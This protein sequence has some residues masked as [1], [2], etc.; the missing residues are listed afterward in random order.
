MTIRTP[1]YD[2]KFDTLGAEPVSWIVKKNKRTNTPIFSSAS[3]K[4]NRVPLELISP[5]GLEGQPRQ[6]PLQ[7]KTGDASLD[8]V[9]SSSTYRVEGIDTNEG[10]VELDACTGERK[11]VTFVL[12]D[13]NQIQV[14]KTF[15]FGA[16]QYD[17]DVAVL[18]KRG[19]DVI[20]QVKLSIGPSIGDQGVGHHTFY[21]V[22]PE[23]IGSLA[24][25]LSGMPPHR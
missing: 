3:T 20:P 22:A 1:L 25:K 18:V 14:R 6:V 15:D 13:A 21:S 9:L 24:E 10:D 8:S 2:A 7:L 5:K 4:N 17:T 16:D 11:Q 23:A 12:E 19:S